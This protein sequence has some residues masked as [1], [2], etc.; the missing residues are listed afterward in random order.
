MELSVAGA[1]GSA[2]L[3]LTTLGGSS[4]LESSDERLGFC[5]ALQPFNADHLRVAALQHASCTSIPPEWGI[6]PLQIGT[7]SHLNTS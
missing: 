7:K 4:A 5:L 1:V 2:A 3:K 6:L